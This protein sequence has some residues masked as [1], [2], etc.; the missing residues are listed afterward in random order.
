MS[1]K[2][3]GIVVALVIFAGA[4]MAW[5]ENPTNLTVIRKSDNTLWKRTCDRTSSC[6]DWAKIGGKF[7]VQPTLTWDQSIQ[8]YILIGIGNNKVSIFR[9]TFEADGTWNNDWTD[10]TG[11]SGGSPS[12]V[13]VSGGALRPQTITVT[14]PEQSLQA[15]VDAA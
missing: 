1:R 15:A 11:T 13:A 3:V 4:A 7:A 5:A 6:S 10:I 12:P 9:S 2:W 8:K 14:C